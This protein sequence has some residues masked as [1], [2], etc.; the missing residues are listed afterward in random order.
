MLLSLLSQSKGF[1]KHWDYLPQ[2]SSNLQDYC[3]LQTKRLVLKDGKARTTLYSP[4]YAGGNKH[5]LT[6]KANGSGS[7][8][9]TL[10]VI[11][12]SKS[13]LLEL[14]L[15]VAKRACQG[16]MRNGPPLPSSNRYILGCAWARKDVLSKDILSSHQPAL[17]GNIILQQLPH[18]SSSL[19]ANFLA[20]SLAEVVKRRQDKV[21]AECSDPSSRCC[22]EKVKTEIASEVMASGQHFQA[23]KAS[24]QA[25][26]AEHLFEAPSVSGPPG[27]L[28]EERCGSPC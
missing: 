15:C 3:N 4:L 28:W 16:E 12:L 24:R 20:L 11:K 2:Y 10:P 17:G 27:G 13:F 6:Y 26:E 7:C 25:S 18:Q 5:L 8:I 22:Q 19:W 21:K 14:C 1:T 23:H 9:I